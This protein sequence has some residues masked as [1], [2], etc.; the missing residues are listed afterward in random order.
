MRLRVAIVAVLVPLVLW[1][2]LPVLSEG[3]A[4]SSRLDS[5]QRKIDITRGK[6]GR[7]KGTE[8]VLSTQIGAYSARIGRLQRSIGSLESRQQ[9]AETDLS[10]KR[11]ELLKL[12]DDLRTQRR[13][14]VRLKA[15]LAQAR[16]ALAQRLTE[17]YTADAPD[18]V[19][20]ILSSK[21]FS[22]LLE[23]G[24]FM[25]RISEQDQQI[26]KLVRSA[27]ADATAL[28]KKLA[29]LEARQQRVTE[30]VQQRRD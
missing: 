29:R 21:G 17:L 8:R 20:V 24:E 14:L 5:V 26:I 22:Q 11:A 23:R 1:G 6:I 30:I 18:I 7:R 9:V 4:P 19:T 16:T 25:Q 2:L 3:A 28:S 12:Q 13:R 27:K 15:R 10:A